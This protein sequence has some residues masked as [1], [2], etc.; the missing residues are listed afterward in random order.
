MTDK[1]ATEIMMGEIV[2]YRLPLGPERGS[3]IRALQW[4][5]KKLEEDQPE[6]RA[7]FIRKRIAILEAR[8]GIQPK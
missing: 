5:R 6:H 7:E 3:T 2:P 4:W 1:T 8:V